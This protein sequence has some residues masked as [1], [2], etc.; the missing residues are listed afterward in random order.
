[1][2]ELFRDGKA[3]LQWNLKSSEWIQVVD[4]KVPWLGLIK[5]KMNE[6]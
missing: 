2:E 1:L 5:K 4:V 3:I 6:V